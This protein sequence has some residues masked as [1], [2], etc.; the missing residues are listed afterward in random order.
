MLNRPQ[1]WKPEGLIKRITDNASVQS[2]LTTKG[3]LTARL[4]TQCPALQVLVLSQRLEVPL[5]NEANALQMQQ[6]EQAWV[7]CV[8]LQCDEHNWVYARTVIPA[9][10]PQ[11]PWESLQKLGNKPLGEVLFEMPSIKRTPFAFSKLPLGT[12]PYLNKSLEAGQKNK[13]SFARRSVFIQQDSPLLLTEVFLPG[14]FSSEN[15]QV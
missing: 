14:L 8:L 1:H 2:W 9:F 4:K 12:W 15:D 7:R 13:P 6:N 11:N 10:N 3:S 5:N